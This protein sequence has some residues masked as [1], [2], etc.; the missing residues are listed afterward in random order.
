MRTLFWKIFLS[1]WAV[2]AAFTIVGILFFRPDAHQ[3]AWQNLVS[4]AFTIEAQKLIQE[5]EG[6]AEPELGR[7]PQ[8]LRQGSYG[9]LFLFDAAGSEL[10]GQK[11][12]SQERDIAKRA[13]VEGQVEFA[14]TGDDA[15]FAERVVSSTGRQYVAVGRFSHVP[16]LTGPPLIRA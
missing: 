5:Y 9:R 2:V 3:R 4:D 14:R 12:P 7:I 8:R 10:A 15:L 6:R 16:G 1:F 13:T 11:V